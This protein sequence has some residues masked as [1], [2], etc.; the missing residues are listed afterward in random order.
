MNNKRRGQGERKNIGMNTQETDDGSGSG[1]NRPDG[2][3]VN[4][5]VV[6]GGEFEVR[7]VD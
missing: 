3:A 1:G 2:E 4:S 6:L 7:A 5:P